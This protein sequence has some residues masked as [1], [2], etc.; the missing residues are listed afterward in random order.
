MPR[1]QVIASENLVENLV[2]DVGVVGNILTQR[3]AYAAGYLEPG[4]EGPLH[5]SN[6][7]EPSRT[8]H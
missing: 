8:G 5:K 6:I 2:N 7:A 1:T 3:T 4:P